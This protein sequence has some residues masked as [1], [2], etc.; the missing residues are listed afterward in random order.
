V[1]RGQNR[2]TP[3]QLA[4]LRLV[5]LGKTSPEIGAAIGLSPRTVDQYVGAACK[6]LGARARIQVVALARQLGLI[7]LDRGGSQDDGGR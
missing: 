5:A 7:A 2:L 6:R 3:R 4:C 1:Y